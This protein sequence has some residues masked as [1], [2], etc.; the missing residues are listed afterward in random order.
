MAFP[1]NGER[2]QLLDDGLLKLTRLEK[3]A[4]VYIAIQMLQKHIEMCVY[5]AIRN[6][7]ILDILTVV[8]GEGIHALE[9][10]LKVLRIVH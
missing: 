9:I 4:R 10:D 7:T 5:L 8:K 1:G 3:Q 6:F 2:I